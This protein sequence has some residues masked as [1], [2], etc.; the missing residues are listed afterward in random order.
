MD[1]IIIAKAEEA[2]RH[3]GEL[4]A[5]IDDHDLTIYEKL[6]SLYLDATKSKEPHSLIFIGNSLEMASHLVHLGTSR[7][8]YLDGIKWAGDTHA[9]ADPRE[10]LAALLLVYIIAVSAETAKGQKVRVEAGEEINKTLKPEDHIDP[11]AVWKKLREI[12]EAAT[13][14]QPGRKNGEQESEGPPNR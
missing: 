11:Q 10:V 1:S 4:A 9:D 7:K 12:V 8:E 2:V 3:C 6:F 14:P 5:F 13:N